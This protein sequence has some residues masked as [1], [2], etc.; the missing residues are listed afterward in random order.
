MGLQNLPDVHSA[1]H[2]QRIEHH[3][4]GGAVLQ[5]GHVLHRD[6]HRHDA[7][8]AMAARHLVAR[9]K[10]ALHGDEDLDHL[11]DARRQLVASLEL[12]DLV[13]KAALKTLLC[14]LVLLVDRLDLALRFLVLKADLPPLTA[15][16]LIEH[17]IG[18][19]L[20]FTSGLGAL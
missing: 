8:V 9:L 13:D 3:V 5:E 4:D 2:T 17:R 19:P 10:L 15:R 18:D 16:N 14:V 12:V 6:D 1:R 20:A 11:H 7:L